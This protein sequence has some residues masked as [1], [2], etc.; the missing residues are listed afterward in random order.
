MITFPEK[1]SR[2]V[3]GCLSLHSHFLYSVQFSSIQRCFI[4]MEI[5]WTILPKQKCA[6]TFA[7]F[8]LR[9]D[10]LKKSLHETADRVSESSGLT[11]T[12][13]LE[14]DIAVEFFQTCTTSQVP[15]SSITF[16]RGQTCLEPISTKLWNRHQND[17]DEKKK[18][19]K[20]KH[21]RCEEEC[22]FL[23]S[24]WAVALKN[25]CLSSWNLQ[26]KLWGCKHVYA[27]TFFCL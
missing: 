26:F 1:Y 6:R 12:W 19:K 15:S 9:G 18:Q 16:K 23:I 11:G 10:T 17:Q 25:V 8:L 21:N 13:F 27:F 2:R 7:N 24:G 22:V 20:K 4:D 14:G 3:S 5:I